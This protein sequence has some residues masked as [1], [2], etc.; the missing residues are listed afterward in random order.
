MCETPNES[1]IYLLFCKRNFVTS[2]FLIASN[3]EATK[4]NENNRNETLAVRRMFN[5]IV[6]SDKPYAK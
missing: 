6:S 1:P 3:D 2:F 4:A 5:R